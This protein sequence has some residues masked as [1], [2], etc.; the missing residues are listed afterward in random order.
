MLWIIAGE[1]ESFSSNSLLALYMKANPY[2]KYTVRQLNDYPTGV[3]AVGIVSTLFWATLTDFLHGKRYLVG[4]WIGITGIVTSAMILS[5][6]A[7]NSTVFAAYYWAGSVYACQAVFFAWANDAMRGQGDSLRAVTL[8]S[9]NAFNNAVN[10]WWSIVFYS[11]D[12][13]PWFTRGMWAM[14]GMCIALLVW[15]AGLS[16]VVARDGKRQ[17][18]PGEVAVSVEAAEPQSEQYASKIG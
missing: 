7:R 18:Y 2:Q 16:W 15:T 14:I 5:P 6:S 8:A 10:A 1:T 17:T 3:P 11:A 4:Y 12:F 9:M 13:A